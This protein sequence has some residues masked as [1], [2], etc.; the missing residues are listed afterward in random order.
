M[1]IN[2]R[3]LATTDNKQH[4]TLFCSYSQ[5]L[6]F[7]SLYTLVFNLHEHVIF[8]T[9]LYKYIFLLI[10]LYIN[11]NMKIKNACIKNT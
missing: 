1:F 11:D 9:I 4:L 10:S 5:V 3:L 2:H 8:T 7:K 6:G